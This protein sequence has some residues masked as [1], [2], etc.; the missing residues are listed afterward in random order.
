MC[1]SACES[2]CGGECVCEG[3]MCVSGHCGAE[4]KVG[5]LGVFGVRVRQ[6][7]SDSEVDSPIFLLGRGKFHFCQTTACLIPLKG[8]GRT[9]S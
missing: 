9:V 8:A 5:R 7:C 4:V 6:M 3:H 2:E 1:E